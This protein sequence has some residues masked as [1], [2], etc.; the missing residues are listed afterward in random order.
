MPLVTS[1]M[2]PFTI[3]LYRAEYDVIS[4]K[5]VSFDCI[6]VYR[7]FLERQSTIEAELPRSSIA[8]SRAPLIS[9]RFYPTR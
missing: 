6:R 2:T 4:K 1:M 7:C 3:T 8:G 9:R 5:E